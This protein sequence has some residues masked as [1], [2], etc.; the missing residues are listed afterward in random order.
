[1]KHTT[2]LEPEKNPHYHKSSPFTLTETVYIR[3]AISS[4]PFP[5]GV[6]C[7]LASLLRL[8]SKQN[9][10]NANQ[11]RSNIV[12]AMCKKKCQEQ[13]APK[14]H[15]TSQR[16]SSDGSTSYLVHVEYPEYLHL[17]FAYA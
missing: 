2:I 8:L 5:A 7:L 1:M 17:D 9:S 4:C 3:I 11:F 10:Q 13:F 12:Y 6:L 16:A 14:K 15:Q